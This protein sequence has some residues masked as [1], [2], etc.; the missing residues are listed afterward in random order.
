MTDIDSVE[1]QRFARAVDRL[2]ERQ[3]TVF[4][5]ISRDGESIIQI[6]GR[7]S[8]AAVEAEYLL[9]DAI[10]QLRRDLDSD[11][12]I[13]NGSILVRLKRVRRRLS[14]RLRYGRSRS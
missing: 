4:R 9:A 11:H 6:A 1:A 14:A 13:R 3:R 12:S 7:M 2:P 5:A 10:V 8:I